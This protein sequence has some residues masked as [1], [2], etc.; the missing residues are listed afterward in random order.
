M[1]RGIKY[2]EA[3]PTHKP[4]EFGDDDEVIV[5]R[6]TLYMEDI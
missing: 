2:I 6:R 4:I 1:A 3:R 5:S